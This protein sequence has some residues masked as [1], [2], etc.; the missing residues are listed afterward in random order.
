MPGEDE[1]GGEHRMQRQTPPHDRIETDSSFIIVRFGSMKGPRKSR[2]VHALYFPIEYA[3]YPTATRICS[4]LRLGSLQFVRFPRTENQRQ[5]AYCR[6]E[7][8]VVWS[9][10]CRVGNV[11]ATVH[12][13]CLKSAKTNYSPGLSGVCRMD[14]HRCRAWW[15]MHKHH[16]RVGD[17]V[18][19]YIQRV[20]QN[21]RP[22]QLG[23]RA[24]PLLLV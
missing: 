2:D 9:G 18:V 6:H 19:R 17:A 5:R 11:G 23:T 8:H 22:Q 4:L 16:L 13:S 3:P 7:C 15:K 21:L 12:P 10:R 20:P 24:Q 1:H 14:E